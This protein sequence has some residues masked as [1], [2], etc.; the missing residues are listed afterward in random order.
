[1]CLSSVEAI[2]PWLMLA[3]DYQQWEGFRL[4]TTAEWEFS[5][6]ARTATRHFFGDSRHD[7]SHYAWWVESSQERLWPVGMKRPNPFGLFDVYGNVMEWCHEPGVPFDPSMHPLRGGSYRTTWQQ[8]DAGLSH[9]IRQCGAFKYR[10]LS[11][12]THAEA[13]PMNWIAVALLI[14]PTG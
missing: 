12:G 7:M 2:G 6:R 8:F 10:G 1:M 3:E 11:C 14:R 13:G 9:A 5:V 4:P